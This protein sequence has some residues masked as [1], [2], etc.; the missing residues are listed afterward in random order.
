MQSKSSLLSAASCWFTTFA[1]PKDDVVLAAPGER[2][3]GMIKVAY[4]GECSLSPLDT[5]FFSFFPLFQPQPQL[6]VKDSN[7]ANFGTKLEYDIKEQ[8]SKTEKACKQ[9]KGGEKKR[10]LTFLPKGAVVGKPGLFAWRV[11]KFK[12]QQVDEP[13][14]FYAGDSYVVLFTRA[15]VRETKTVL[16]HDV[17]FWLGG[18]TSQDEAGTAV[19]V[20]VVVWVMFLNLKTKQA[21]K[22]VELDDFLKRE[23]VQHRE[24]Q[25]HESEL[26]LSYFIEA[27]GIRVLEGGFETG[28]NII[29]PE[30]WS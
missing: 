30:S 17:H 18:T 22:S 15:V 6:A 16:M 4:N 25:A 19:S 29:K 27:G 13:G 1:T 9:K 26:F 12:L 8:A 14:L 20:L 2:S 5:R 11:N 23:A 24:V 21:Y 3:I 28:F 10:G 7:M